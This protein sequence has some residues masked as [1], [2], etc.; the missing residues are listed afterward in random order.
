MVFCAIAGHAKSWA[1]HSRPI[2]PISSLFKEVIDVASKRELAS[3]STVGS[4]HQP[5]LRPVSSCQGVPV[6]VMTGVPQASASATTIPKFSQ[7]F[8]F[9]VFLYSF[10]ISLVVG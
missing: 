9:D 1:I 3:A 7:V 6:V 5:H 2:T 8:V 10:L 4:T